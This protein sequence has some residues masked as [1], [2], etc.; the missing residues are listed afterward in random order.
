[1]AADGVG[2]KHLIICPHRWLDYQ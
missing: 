2:V 1:M